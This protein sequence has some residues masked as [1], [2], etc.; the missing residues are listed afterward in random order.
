MQLFILA[1]CVPCIDGTFCCGRIFGVCICGLPDIKDCCN[2]ITDPI[3]EAANFGCE[4][5][6]ATAN[7]GI[8]VAEGVVEGARQ[9][10]T[11]AKLALEAAQEIV[12]ASQVT[13][14]IANG[15]L[16]AAAATYRFGTEAAT[17]IAEFGLTGLINIREISFDVG[18]SAA[19]GGQFSASIRA[20]FLGSD[21]VTLSLSIN[22]RDIVS[23][24]KDLAEEIGEGFS[25]LFGRLVAV[26]C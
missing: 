16:E 19:T 21:E 3:C 26:V 11:L 17:A 20:S 15:V 12:D 6:R 9:T 10:L 24:A 13:L 25:S 5:L 14:D 18:L 23:I 8:D 22:V 7:L 1:V 4:A 2:R